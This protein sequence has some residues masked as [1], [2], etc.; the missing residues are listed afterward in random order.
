MLEFLYLQG[1][2]RKSSYKGRVRIRSVLRKFVKRIEC[3]FRELKQQ[4]G[5]FCYRFWSKHMPKLSYYQKKGEPT[6]LE[7]VKNEKSRKK[8]LEAVRAIEMHMALSCIAMGILQ[9]LSIYFIGKVRSSQLRYQRTPS[10]GRVSEAAL[11]HYFR[12][13]FFRLLGQKPELRI[14][15]IIHGL[16]KSSEEQ[17]NS[18][19]S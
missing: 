12:K 19:V 6:P 1:S 18:L 7:H 5:A 4:V 13:H 14:T 16:Q 11:M 9:S 17:W 10:K 15:Q 2:S 3:T 8:V